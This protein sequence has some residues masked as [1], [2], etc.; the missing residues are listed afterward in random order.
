MA[1]AAAKITAAPLAPG[2]EPRDTTPGHRPRRG[3]TNAAGLGAPFPGSLGNSAIQEPLQRRLFSPILKTHAPPTG[4]DSGFGA[5]PPLL[6]TPQHQTNLGK[7]NNQTGTE[8][9]PT[10]SQAS[11]GTPR[12]ARASR[13]SLLTGRQQGLSCPVWRASRGG[14]V[15]ESR[16]I[17]LDG[18]LARAR[19]GP[20]LLLCNQ[21]RSI[22]SRRVGSSGFSFSSPSWDV[23]PYS[24]P[25]QPCA[26]TAFAP[27]SSPVKITKG[28]K[29]VLRCWVLLW[30]EEPTMICWP[31]H[32]YS[33]TQ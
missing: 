16:A 11:P 5:A 12:P 21:Q 10:G 15:E 17:Y 20:R 4:G 26:A 7:I 25:A 23:R 13:S 33:L 31:S 19:G 24:A 29:S 22:A 8:Y 9:E 2:R 28:T 14:R 1:I 27:E 6:E 18:I 32:N 30:V 3:A